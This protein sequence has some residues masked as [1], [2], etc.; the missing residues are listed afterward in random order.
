MID[1]CKVCL[2]EEGFNS[3]KNHHTIAGIRLFSVTPQLFS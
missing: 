2:K 1:N 3:R